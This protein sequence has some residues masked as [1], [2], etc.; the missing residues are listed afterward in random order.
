MTTTPNLA[1]LVEAVGRSDVRVRSLA[2]PGEDPHFVEARPSFVRLLHS[3]DLLAVVGLDL[4]A[5]YV[6]ALVA[7]AR[8]AEIQPGRPG[9]FDASVGVG[10]ILPSRTGVMARALGDIHPMGN[11]HYLLD[12]AEGLRVARRLAE[13]LSQLKPGA[14]SSFEKNYMT[15]RDELLT[16]LYGRQAVGTVGP[17]ALATSSFQ[18]GGSAR[19]LLRSRGVS[20]GG[21]EQEVEPYRGS[22]FVADH[23]M[24]PY[25]ARRFGLEQMALLEPYPGVAPTVRH[26][27]KVIEEMRAKKVR[28]I[29]SSSYFRDEYA[30]KVARETDARVATMAD[31]V[32]VDPTGDTYL[33]MIQANVDRVLATLRKP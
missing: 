13:R 32:G 24:W 19:A 27:Q 22:L 12:P 5:G 33:D 28:I 3:A 17:Q 20:L 11:P 23:N 16:K 10:K 18:G 29:L 4:G 31:Q 26:L 9:Y 30:K 7:Q 14:R 6:P 25:F 2:R 21:W 8:N 1:A 15:F